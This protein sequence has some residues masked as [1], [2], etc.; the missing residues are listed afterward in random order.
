M[1]LLLWPK[2]VNESSPTLRTLLPERSGLEKTC[3][4]LSRWSRPQKWLKSSA[5]QAKWPWVKIPP[6]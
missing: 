4:C 3:C 2:T 6:Q 5:P 1:M